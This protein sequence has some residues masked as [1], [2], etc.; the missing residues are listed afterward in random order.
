LDIQCRDCGV[1]FEFSDGEAK[2]YQERNYSVPVRCKPCRELQKARR[3][4]SSTGSNPPTPVPTVATPSPSPRKRVIVM[5]EERK[6][7]RKERTRRDTR[8]HP[9]YDED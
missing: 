9:E 1:L 8:I 7:P 4:G 2:F 5:D 6:P 3:Q